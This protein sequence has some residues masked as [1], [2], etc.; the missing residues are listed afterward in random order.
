MFTTKEPVDAVLFLTLQAQE[1]NGCDP[2]SE[3]IDE[4]LR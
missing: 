2:V 3:A 1:V 4:S